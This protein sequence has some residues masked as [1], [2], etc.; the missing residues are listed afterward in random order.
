MRLGTGFHEL[1]MQ[2]VSDCMLNY[3]AL[4]T[5]SRV[6]I[7]LYSY[8]GSA[9]DFVIHVIPIFLSPEE[10]QWESIRQYYNV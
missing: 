8:C 1:G 7:G 3:S 10:N 5:R 4:I 6:T 9:L 2:H